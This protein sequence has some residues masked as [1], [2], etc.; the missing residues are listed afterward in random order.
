MVAA[1]EIETVS[2][3]CRYDS[4]IL[5]TFINLD[6]GVAV[7]MS[8]IIRSTFLFCLLP[9][10][11]QTKKTKKWVAKN[12]VHE[13]FFSLSI[14]NVPHIIFGVA[15]IVFVFRLTINREKKKRKRLNTSHITVKKCRNFIFHTE[16]DARESHHNRK[17]RFNWVC[18]AF[19]LSLVVV[20]RSTKTKWN[21]SMQTS[22]YLMKV[23]SKWCTQLILQLLRHHKHS[24]SYL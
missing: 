6:D 10:A 22:L 9:M 8:F 18:F 24:D 13:Q 12:H 1:H 23:S 2:S 16:S 5:P 17:W 20:V 21:W 11:K 3:V 7:C 15:I 19:L 14:P 4:L